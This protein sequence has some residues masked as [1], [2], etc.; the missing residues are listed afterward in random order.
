MKHELK[1]NLSK[2][3]LLCMWLLLIFMIP[4]SLFSQQVVSA[5]GTVFESETTS[6]SWTLGE[7]AIETLSTENSTLTQGFHQPTLT[8]VSVKEWAK[9]DFNIQAF[10]NPT[11]DFLMIRLDEMPC[12][13]MEFRMYNMNGQMVE[14]GKIS[15]LH[16]RISFE[17]QRAA[18]YMV[19][20]L[21]HN[22]AIKTFKIHK[23]R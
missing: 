17:N 21:R 11:R 6:I 22:Q 1:K 20:I 12:E 3:L 9:L 18:Y 19:Q 10:P 15:E 16:T 5:A 23:T 4:Y 13:N 14:Q 8:I 2:T 7:T